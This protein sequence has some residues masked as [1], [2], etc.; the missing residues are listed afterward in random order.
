M[1]LLT[2]TITVVILQYASLKSSVAKKFL[3][4]RP[5]IVIENGIILEEEMEKLRYTLTDL[6]EQLRNK[7]IFD[8]SQSGICNY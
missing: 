3:V 7:G 4:G 5:T 2:W 8:L 6:L 1:G